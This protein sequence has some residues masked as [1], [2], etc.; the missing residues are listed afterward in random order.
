ML[1]HAFHILHHVVVPNSN[2]VIPFTVEP[3]SSLVVIGFVNRML[4]TIYL[5]EQNFVLTKEVR[6]ITSE[7]YLALKF[8]V[9]ELATTEM[10]PQFH[11][12]TRMGLPK[13]LRTFCF[14]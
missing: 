3:F 6:N 5:N 2:D 10:P 4:A 12:G 8:C 7:R 9:S 14:R 1:K 13:L 11:L